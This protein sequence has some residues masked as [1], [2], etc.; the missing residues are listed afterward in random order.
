M[1]LAI[2]IPDDIAAHLR[3]TQGGD[4]ARTAIEQ[5]ALAGYLVG[6]LSRYQVQRLLGFDNRW[7]TE[8]WLGSHGATMQYT[9][10]ELDRDRVNLDHV[11]GR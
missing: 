2:T 7:E 11:L 3:A 5:I 4:L 8:D 9:T 6:T 1:Q 10:A